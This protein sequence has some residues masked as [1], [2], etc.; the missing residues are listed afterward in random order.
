[1]ILKTTLTEVVKSQRDSFLNT[2][3][4]VQREILKDIKLTPGVATVITGIRRAGKS[5]LLRQLINNKSLFNYLNFEDVKI[6]GFDLRDFVRLEEVFSESGNSDLFFFDEIQN[7]DGW[8]RYIRTLLDKRKT[9]IITGS[10]ASLLSRELGTR[11]TGRHRSIEIYP[12]SFN[13]FLSLKKAKPYIKLFDNYFTSGGFPLF[14]NEPDEAVLQELFNDIIARDITVKYSLRN[15]K[16]V[17]ELA[18]NLILNVGKE[19]SYQKLKKNYS[20]GS[21]NTVI[22]L[23]GYYEE[24]Y[25]LFTVPQFDYSLKKQQVNAKKIYCVDNGLINSNSVSFSSDAG[26]KLENLVFVQLKR[27]GSDVFYFSKDTECDF[28]ARFPNKQL[29]TYQVCFSLTEDNKDREINGLLEALRHIKQKE[30]II[31]TYDQKDEFEVDGNKV[32]VMPVWEWLL[33]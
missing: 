6:F 7:V 11:L 13:E 27:M 21:V 31:L 26:K 17:K 1:M 18:L 29:K 33:N 9:V 19:F 30:G 3:M 4:G 32:I 28:I 2:D 22:S 8:E 25:L 12:F 20:I 14:L 24:S 15:S 16:L 23:V 5:T 10:N